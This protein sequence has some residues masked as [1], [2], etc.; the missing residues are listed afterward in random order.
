MTKPTI[1]IVTP[2]YNEQECL[3]NFFKRVIP[4]MENIGL[5]F[6]IIAVNDGSKDKTPQILREQCQKDSRVKAIN[7]SRNFGQQA[8]FLCG[9]KN[10]SGDCAI[11]ID[12]DLQD[13]PELFS[14]L[15]EKW[16]EGYEV[17]HGVRKVRK[18]ESFFKKFTSSLFIKLLTKSSGLDI[19]PN[20]GEFKLYDRKVID[21][22]C[23]LPERSRYLRVQVA[24]VG[25]RQTSIEF[26]RDERTAGETKFTLKKMLKTAEAGIVPYSPKVL[27]LSGKLGVV[28]CILSLLTFAVFT[29]LAILKTAL[30][31]TAWL[32]PSIALATSIILISNGIT[33]LYV[34][35]LYED[36]KARPI[37]IESEKI[38]F[39]E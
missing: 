4:I 24:W 35:Y 37:Y 29:I 27:K 38:N 30:P 17:V 5:P 2:I 7:F 19:P 18:G 32:F 31:L 16:K 8:A 3:P 20:S 23:G 1:S 21:A 34:G 11:L 26:D 33:D 6:E 25:F 28:G 9:L 12:A 22:I 39:W 14:S 36:V 10:C 13:P 15:I